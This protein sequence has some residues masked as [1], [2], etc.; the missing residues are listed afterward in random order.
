VSKATVRDF[1]LP[2]TDPDYEVR[3]R[4]SFE[5]Q[6]F[7]D[8]IGARL[9]TLRPGE[10][11]IELPFSCHLTQ[12]HGF[13]HAGSITSIVDSACGYAALSL[14]PRGSAVLSVE[15][16]INFTK[17][18]AGSMFRATGKVLKSGRSLSVCTGIVEAQ[19]GNNWSLIAIMQA[20]M[21]ALADQEKLKD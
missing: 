10:A 2:M 17:P 15:F 8:T 6:R 14:M 9:V 16:K 5:K 20:T 4:S 3:C 18:A 12:Q 1:L 19:E 7:M 11:V 13:L 21:I